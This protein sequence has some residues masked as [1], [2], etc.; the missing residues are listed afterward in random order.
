MFSKIK[1]INRHDLVYFPF[2]RVE[3]TSSKNWFFSKRIAVNKAAHSVR[4]E[5]TNRSLLALGQA[6]KGQ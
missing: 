5:N 2:L 4:P 3:P 1:K 6:L